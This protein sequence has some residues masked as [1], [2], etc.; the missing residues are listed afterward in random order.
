MRINIM[1]KYQVKYKNKYSYRVEDEVHDKIF[2][3]G[4]HKWNRKMDGGKLIELIA[5]I[6]RESDFLEITSNETEI[7]IT[8]FEPLTG[9]SADITVKYTRLE[10]KGN[11][12][13]TK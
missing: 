11:R 6:M 8:L 1:S 2:K 3:H 12:N 10:N 4:I 13:D 7:Q 5:H 9:E